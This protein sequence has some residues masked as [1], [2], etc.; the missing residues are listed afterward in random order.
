MEDQ[1]K[2]LEEFDRHLF[3]HIGYSIGNAVRSMVLGLS[4]ARFAAVPT[5]RKTARYYRKLTRYSAALAF[6]SDIAMLML[7]GKLKH[8]ERISGRLGDVSEPVIHLLGHA[9]TV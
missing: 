2:G 1:E 5:D 8:K 3:G 7:G 9:E 6:A 4:F